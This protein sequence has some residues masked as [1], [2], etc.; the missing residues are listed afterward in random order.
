MGCTPWLPF[1]G[2]TQSPPFSLIRDDVSLWECIASA[3]ASVFAKFVMAVESCS[4]SRPL[5]TS[6]KA[7][8]PGE[9]PLRSMNSLKNSCLYLA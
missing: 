5:N 2:R 3:A 4:G 6:E 9:P 8:W 1:V 7:P